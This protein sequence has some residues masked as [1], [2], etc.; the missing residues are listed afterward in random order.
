[1]PRQRDSSFNADRAGNPLDPF[2]DAFVSL[3]LALL[4]SL[5][6]GR[7][8]SRFGIPRVTVYLLVGLLLGP[9]LGLRWVDSES[10]AARLLG[11]AVE[12]PLR[13]LQEL[14][15]G[16]ILF[17]IGAAF[18]FQTLQGRDFLRGGEEHTL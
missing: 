11:P 4:L 1:M 15:V 5:G 9:Q 7:A 14:G 10:G 18:R 6:L 12:A 8:S 3:S 16:F 17:G 2:F 13:A